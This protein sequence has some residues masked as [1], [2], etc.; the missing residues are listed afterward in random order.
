MMRW[1]ALS[2]VGFA[3]LTSSCGREKEP[4]VICAADAALSKQDFVRVITDDRAFPVRHDVS[5]DGLAK[6]PGVEAVG[7]GRLQGLTVAR[8]SFGMRLEY[9]MAPAARPKLSCAT[10]KTLT[11]DLSPADAVI[12]VPSDYP[13]E[14]C[15]YEQIL[16]HE[17]QHEDIYKDLLNETAEKTR[18]AFKAATWLP[19]P[20][21]PIPTPD[22]ADID[23]R[24]QA[25]IEKI[26]TP[27]YEEYKEE[28]N[29]R[30]AVIDIPENYHWV[31]V[32]CKDWK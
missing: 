15:E 5:I 1:S 32:R 12:Y 24:T 16:A 8:P 11:I 17:H 18:A 30:Q 23:A 4:Q 9:D 7:A 19:G 28:L 22:R 27:V 14:S 26:M 25:M 6:I 21:R 10:I 3:I 29:K 20:G 2:A 31:S 13:V